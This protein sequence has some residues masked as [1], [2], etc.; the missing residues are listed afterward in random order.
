MGQTTDP[1]VVVSRSHL[2]FFICVHLAFMLN[3]ELRSQLIIMSHPELQEVI[4]YF[5]R[6]Y[7]KRA[8]CIDGR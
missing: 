6:G 4:P 8:Y 2:P 7:K 5:M 1:K 3:S